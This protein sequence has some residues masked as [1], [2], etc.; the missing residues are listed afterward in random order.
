V[1]FFNCSGANSIQRQSFVPIDVPT[2]RSAAVFNRER[3]YLTR[4][5]GAT[6]AHALE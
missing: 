3:R 2:V 6:V 1:N 4:G 5:F